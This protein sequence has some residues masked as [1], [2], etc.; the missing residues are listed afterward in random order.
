MAIVGAGSIGLAIAW[1]IAR[2]GAEVVVYDP[3]PGSGASR[4]AAGMLAAVTEAQFGEEA[5]LPFMAES[6]DAWPGFARELEQASGHHVGFRDAPTLLV[7]L[8]DA[9][10]AEIDRQAALYRST[11]RNVQPLG[12]RASRKIEPLLSHRTRG[13]VLVPDDRA[14]DPR[15]VHAALLAAAEKAGARIRTEHVDDLGALDA[16]KI[17]LATGCGSA[18]F[19]LPIRPVRG[20]VLRLRAGD[21]QP[22]PAATV[23]GYVQ[24][25]PVYIV[26]RDSGEIVIG[27]TSDERGFDRTIGTAGA[28][29]DL[30]RWSIELIPE[31]AEYHLEEVT[32]G[33]RPTAPDNLP[34]IGPVDDRTIAA[35]GHY[36]HGIAL[37]PAT[38]ACV[39]DLAT[40]QGDGFPKAFDPLRFKESE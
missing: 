37:I 16:D 8:E 2:F 14:V 3:A 40:G 27:A 12:G 19:G 35:T 18:R 6:A 34:L 28:V 9:D 39:A 32:V 33:F 36:R 26:T 24:G 30:L 15:A 23:R 5:L 17:V 31:I 29:H 11:D 10:R 25:H 1:R 4:V 13:G 7:G 22:V 21:G 20:T 38:A